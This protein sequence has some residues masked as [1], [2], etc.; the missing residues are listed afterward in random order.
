M[1]DLSNDRRATII[2]GWLKRS[3]DVVVSAALLIAVLPLFAIISVLVRLTD[4][5]DVLYRQ[6]RIG[7]GGK[8]FQCLKFRTMVLNGDEVLDQYLQANPE[9]AENWKKYRKLKHDPRI[10]GFVGQFLRKKSLDELPQLINV[11]RGEMSL[12]GPRPVTEVEYDSYYKDTAVYTQARPG[13]TGLW[14]ISGRNEITFE[15][16]VALDRSYVKNWSLQNDLSILVKTPV[17]VVTGAG[18]Y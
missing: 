10:L 6:R 2:G 11:L 9:D 18:A 16:R 7:C 15:E 8:P 5:N 14:Q 12:V 13:I 3:F 17:V 1:Q 4:G